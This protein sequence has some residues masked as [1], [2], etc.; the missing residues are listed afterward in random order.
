[1]LSQPLE[2]EVL[3]NTCNRLSIY[4]HRRYRKE[5]RNVYK[6]IDDKITRPAEEK[7]RKEY[8]DALE[9]GKDATTAKKTRF[10]QL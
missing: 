2:T 10:V 4:T 8:R 3:A 6:Q 9:A 7:A 1:M 5:K